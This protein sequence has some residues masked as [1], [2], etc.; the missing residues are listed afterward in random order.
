MMSMYEQIHEGRVEQNRA[1]SIKIVATQQ[2][3]TKDED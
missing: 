2:Y 3:D 1:Y